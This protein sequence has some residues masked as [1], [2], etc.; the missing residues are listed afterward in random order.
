MNNSKVLPSIH[1]HKGIEEQNNLHANLSADN[2]NG[3]GE[4]YKTDVVDPN[5]PHM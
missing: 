2:M 4:E 5:A 3:P 1:S